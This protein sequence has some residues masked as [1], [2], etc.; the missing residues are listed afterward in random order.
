M[1]L[2]AGKFGQLV[3]KASGGCRLATIQVLETASQFGEATVADGFGKTNDGSFADFQ[4]F[5]QISR[6]EKGG[7][8]IARQ[9]IVGNA[10]LTF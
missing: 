4:V 9:Q 6:G 5:R 1:A 10:L 2:V 8:I 7:L 3:L